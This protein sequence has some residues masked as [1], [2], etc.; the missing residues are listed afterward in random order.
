MLHR[1]GRVGVLVNRSA[2][3]VPW[4]PIGSPRVGGSVR[5]HSLLEE[6]LVTPEY[7]P[8]LAPVLVKPILKADKMSAVEEAKKVCNGKIRKFHSLLRR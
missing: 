3:E 6:F 2:P 7:S 8:L 4:T 5:G 1:V